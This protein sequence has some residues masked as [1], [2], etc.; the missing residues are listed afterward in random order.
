[1]KFIFTSSLA[2][3]GGE[4]PPVID[5]R[6]A[7]TPQSSYG[8]QK[9]MCE[10]LINDYARKG[11]VDGRAAPAHH[12]RAAGQAEQGGIVVRQRHHPRAAAR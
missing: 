11:F 2:V 5:D 3:F 1:M 6:S 9:A 8:A 10:L 4:L 7:V 12:Q